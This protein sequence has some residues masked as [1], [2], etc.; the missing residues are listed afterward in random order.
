MK[1]LGDEN[2]CLYCG[3]KL[4]QKIADYDYYYECDCKD[5][6]ECRRIDREIEKLK[7]SKPQEKY[8]ITQERVLCKLYNENML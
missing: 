7:Y 2:V 4:N 1:M 8:I 5:A 3:V 6:I